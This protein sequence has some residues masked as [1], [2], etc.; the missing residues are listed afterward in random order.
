MSRIGEEETARKGGISEWH[1][2][3]RRG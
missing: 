2:H 1:V 3:K